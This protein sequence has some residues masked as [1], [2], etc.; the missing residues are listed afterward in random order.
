MRIDIDNIVEAVLDIPPPPC[1]QPCK[2]YAMCGKYSMACEGFAVYLGST[3]RKGREDKDILQVPTSDL[4]AALFPDND[5]R[6]KNRPLLQAAL[7]DM[8]ARVAD[9]PVKAA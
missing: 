9:T 5:N 3:D 2:H 1:E 8:R 7:R 4:F 6:E